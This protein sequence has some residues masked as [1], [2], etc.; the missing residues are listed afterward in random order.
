ML[1]F[2]YTAEALWIIAQCFISWRLLDEMVEER[3]RHGII[4][5][6]LLLLSLSMAA[7]EI[8]N[9]GVCNII[10]SHGT[11]TI[12]SFLFAVIAVLLYKKKTVSKI[13]TCILVWE[14]G[15]L[16]DY[17]VQT[18]LYDILKADEVD[19]RLFQVIGLPRSI[20]LLLY[21][22][23]LCLF[24]R[25]IAYAYNKYV[26]GSWLLRWH[27]IV[28]SVSFWFLLSYLQ[29]IYYSTKDMV[30]E[31]YLFI[32]Q[33][34]IFVVVIFVVTLWILHRRWKL[35]EENRLQRQQIEFMEKK[36][37]Q[38]IEQ[39]Q[40]RRQLVHDS[41]NN[42]LTLQ[43]LIDKG[44]LSAAKQ[45]IDELI[46]N[47]K[48]TDVYRWSGHDVLDMIFSIKAEAAKSVDIECR[49]FL[50]DITGIRLTDVEISSLFSNL[51]DNAI[52]AQM[53]KVGIAEKWIEVKVKKNQKTLFIN[54]QNPYEGTIKFE[55]GIPKTSKKNE[56]EHGIGSL[57]IQR[58]IRRYDGVLRIRTERHIFDIS[59]MMNAF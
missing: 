57:L 29:R 33:L 3:F 43:H 7:Y 16:L 44:D 46:P 5:S 17:F 39:Y 35:L 11:L 4:M 20:L 18:I 8:Y 15:R 56:D 41:K 1:W 14:F 42:Y 31:G 10:A 24:S 55:D 34:F 47:K 28:F 53:D 23:V 25:K 30:D 12:Y 13:Q 6:V 54:I 26:T 36:H 37:E 27:G 52:E 51:L 59:I 21:S 38:L 22:V 49:F 19:P 32:W 9:V 40:E 45:F 50:D 48:Q 58:I 2:A